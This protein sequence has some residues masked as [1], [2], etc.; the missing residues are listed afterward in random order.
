MQSSTAPWPDDVV[1]FA[2]KCLRRQTE[3][4]HLGVGHFTPGGILAPIEATG[5]GQ[6]LGR[7]RA[8][9]QAHDRLVVSQR[10]AA[11]IRGDEGKEP[12]LHLVP[13]AGARRKVAD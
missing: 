1:P 7:R 10:L 4:W 2:M 9:D 3:L 11:P 12:V 5:D 13:F 6:P 8:R